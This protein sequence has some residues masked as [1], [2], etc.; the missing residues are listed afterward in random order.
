M[1]FI[2]KWLCITSI[3]F[4]YIQV[5]A[6]ELPWDDEGRV[7]VGG[8]ITEGAYGPIYESIEQHYTER[9]GAYPEFIIWEEGDW[10]PVTKWVVSFRKYYYEQI[11]VLPDT[12]TWGDVRPYV[13]CICS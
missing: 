12:L 9:F 3:L 11:H 1:R 13:W 8:R 10:H 7:R 6:V 4:C 5:Y 2:V